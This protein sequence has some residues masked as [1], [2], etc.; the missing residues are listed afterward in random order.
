MGIGGHFPTLFFMSHLLQPPS[1]V[2]VGDITIGGG[3][4]EKRRMGQGLGRQ[5]PKYK[6]HKTRA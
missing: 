5:S 4:A 2:T 6:P 3:N 1:L